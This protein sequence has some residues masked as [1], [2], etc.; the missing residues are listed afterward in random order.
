[1]RIRYSSI[2]ALGFLCFI[3][4]AAGLAYTFV[5]EAGQARATESVE[6]ERVLDAAGVR[7]LSISSSIGHVRL[8]LEE[9]DKIRVRLTG[10]VPDKLKKQLTLKA[11]TA[12]DRLVVD[13]DTG[14][15]NIGLNLSQWISWIKQESIQLEVIVPPT[16][17]DSVKIKSDI[18]TAHVD[19]LQASRLDL[20]SDTG[21]VTVS[22]FEGGQVTAKSAVG[23][24]DL[25]SIR[26]DQLTVRSDTGKIEVDGFTGK[27]LDV[28]SDIGTVLLNNID[29]P[30]Q[31]KTDTG[32]IELKADTI[33]HDVDLATDIGGVE[34][35]MNRIPAALQ[36]DLYS[37]L[38]KVAFHPDGAKYDVK[39]SSRLKGSIGSDGPVLRIQTE[40]GKITVR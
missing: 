16:V 17:Y 7:D 10:T 8:I 3:I 27:R 32:K 26:S 5:S 39:E 25:T 21:K 23:V 12:G 1:M 19:R 33:L 20:E 31:A 36:F 22:R 30:I 28:K 4:G 15:V 13:L 24:I 11:E 18:G 38:G 37:S 14:K 40:I 29:S 2:V 9:T 35:I 34:V 6:T